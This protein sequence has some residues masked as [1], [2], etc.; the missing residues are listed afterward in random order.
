MQTFYF[1]CKGTADDRYTAGIMEAESKEAAQK[2]LDDLYNVKRNAAGKQTN[3]DVIEVELI[4][5]R[6]FSEMENE[7][8][9]DLTVKLGGVN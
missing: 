5:E 8:G 3:T 9:R 2:R 7:Y 4:T 1:K 6:E